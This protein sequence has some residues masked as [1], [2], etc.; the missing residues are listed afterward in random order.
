M[1]RLLK[2]LAGI[3]L[4][5]S[6]L[7]ILAII[8][9]PRVFD[10]NDYRQAITE[11]VKDNTGR[12][13]VLNGDLSVSVFPWLGIRTEQLSFSQPPEIG[14]SQGAMLQVKTAQLRMKL[15]PLLSKQV[16]I[17]KVILEQ[18]QVR[19]VTLE[20]GVSSLSGLVEEQG[21]DEAQ[22]DESNTETAN[23]DMAIALVIQGL[24][25][26]DGSLD[27]DDRS[28][29]QRYQI[30]NFNILTGNL[31]GNKLADLYVSGEL[32]DSNQQYPISIE[33]EGKAVIDVD[34][35][36][37]DGQSLQANLG[38]GENTAVLELESIVLNQT[39]LGVAADINGLS[40]NTNVD[41]SLTDQI[42]SA[43]LSANIDKLSF[44]NVSKLLKISSVE[45]DLSA[46]IP[47]QP[48]I[49]AKINAPQLNY[50][51]ELSRFDSQELSLN[52]ELDGRP[53]DITTPNVQ[54]DLNSQILSLGALSLS[55]QDLSIDVSEM[56]VKQLLD[57]P[58]AK[59]SIII[60]DFDAS[61]LIEDLDLDYRPADQKALKNLSM[62]A[63]FDAG[64]DYASISD[65]MLQVDQSKLLGSF[66]V[67][68]Y[69]NPSV[70][71]KLNL[72]SINLD[73]YLPES[74]QNSSNT[75]SATEFDGGAQALAV[76]MALFKDINANGD[77]TATRL[78][79]SGVELEDI[80]VR[81]ASSAGN[82]TI[83]P[84]AN[85]YDGKIDGSMEFTQQQGGE[86]KLRINN[87]IDLVDLSE[88]LTAADVTDQLSGI[89]SLALDITV[90]ER[91]G[92]QTNNGTIKLFAKDGAIQGVDIKGIIDSGY[93]KYQQLKGE[94]A[95]Q[96]EGQGEQNDETK[97]AELLGT[98]NLNDYQITNDD[99]NLKAPLFRV[100]GEGDINLE[101]EQLNYLVKV[102]VVNSTEGQGG[103]AIDKLAGITLPIRFKGS[104]FSPSYSLDMK[105]LYKGMA[106][107]KVDEKKA[108][109]LAEELGIEDGEKLS[110]KD[111]FKQ[112]LSKEI[113]EQVN[114]KEA[115]EETQTEQAVVPIAEV[116]PVDESSTDSD[117]TS[118]QQDKEPEEEQLSAEDQLKEDL[119]N[120]LLDG[121]FN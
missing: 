48:R 80:N 96:Q 65:L 114:D 76:P 31:I 111:I 47:K 120:K 70:N 93:Q 9:V 21:D 89:G 102:S 25:L 64:T 11:L 55:S 109:Y 72:N 42:S 107:K 46:E 88:F 112:L 85:L 81:V 117:K 18:P 29:Q 73:H 39:D 103:D 116:E 32:I 52:A 40:L 97:F 74:Q 78:I 28:Q 43:N 67:K 16:E 58:N 41:N 59:G 92:V 99:F 75:Q 77:F 79:S 44:D 13:L 36:Q 82:V 115:T 87:N 30:N 57:S 113:D 104:L 33:I 62:N 94:S 12:N 108:E 19:I 60:S 118:D 15:L 14:D 121:L 3:L 69:A 98:F 24:E 51:L 53:F 86:S 2:W 37:V 23:S 1:L 45:A 26:T 90:T 8:I 5:I 27:W 63:N 95:D 84:K 34:T 7:L 22:A 83:T 101:Q 119:K 35:L 20:N 17:D 68:N 106:K 110:T 56:K 10:P 91:D 49:K 66:S 54:A 50:N 105:A 4:T 61:K 100:S 38:M 71:F 6:V